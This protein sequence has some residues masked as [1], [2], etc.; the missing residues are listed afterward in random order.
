MIKIT[1]L[2]KFALEQVYRPYFFTLTGKSDWLEKLNKEYN[3]ENVMNHL[4]GNKPFALQV[5]ARI[6]EVGFTFAPYLREHD[7]VKYI[8]NQNN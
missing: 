1:D 2:E 5:L 7:L 8:N 6:R 3:L 4:R